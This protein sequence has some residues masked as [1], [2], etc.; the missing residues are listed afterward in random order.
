MLRNVAAMTVLIAA[1][2]VFAVAA[3]VTWDLG[4]ENHVSTTVDIK[5]LHPTDPGWSRRL[6]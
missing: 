1:L 5:S 6:E 4:E 2:A 3:E